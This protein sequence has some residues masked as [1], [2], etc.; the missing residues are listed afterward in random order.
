MAN[1][2]FKYAERN[3]ENRIN[4]AEVGKDMTDMLAD[5]AR[6][7][8]EKK[9]AI[10]ADFR[11]FGKALSEAPMGE[12]AGRN[13][14]IT[15]YAND[16]S[17]YS[18]MINRLLKSGDLKLRDYNNV[19]A[20]L[21]EGTD[22]A[23]SLTKE[24]NT[25]FKLFQERS[26]IN[27]ETGLPYNQD[28][29]E[30]VLGN[31]QGFGNYADH[32]LWINPTTGRLSLGKTVTDDKGNVTLSKD[33]GS[34]VPVNS[35]R[36]RIRTQYDMYDMNAASAGMVEQ[37]KELIVVKKKDGVLTES[38]PTKDKDVQK[39]L[40][41]HAESVVAI[42][43][44]VSSILTNTV[45]TNP[46]SETGESFG[47]TYVPSEAAEN[48]NLILLINN[49]L[50]ESAGIPMPAFLD[51][52]EAL[53]KYLRK[54]YGSGS[55]LDETSENYVSEDEIK[56]IV[57]NNTK[58]I[59][60]A[61]DTVKTSLLSKIDY[62]ETPT[63]IFDPNR[64]AV[65]Y[66]QQAESRRI[67]KTAVTNLADIW[68]GTKSEMGAA[69]GF[70]EGL[71]PNVVKIYA[72]PNN[73][74]NILI[75]RNV[76]GKVVTMLPFP[77]GDSVEDFVTRIYTNIVPG[78]K[79]LDRAL[80]DSGI[81]DKMEEVDGV[82]VKKKKTQNQGAAGIDNTVS[83]GPRPFSAIVA[84]GSDEL[85]MTSENYH[86]EAFEGV[87]VNEGRKQAS[88]ETSV[89]SQSGVLDAQVKYMPEVEAVVSEFW[90][91]DYP[92]TSIYVPG[93]MNMPILVPSNQDATVFKE[94]NRL[95]MDSYKYNPPKRLTPN[96]FKNLFLTSK[97]FDKYNN[98]KVTEKFFK[99][100]N[101]EGGVGSSKAE[102]AA[103]KAA[104]LAKKEADAAAATGAPDTTTGSGS[105][106][107]I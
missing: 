43:T 88:A 60:V 30:F 97:I 106:D 92:A 10:D 89:L 82:M 1:T 105:L 103:N 98:Q 34:F 66:L 33:T 57:A 93:V 104:A 84:G 100:F 9:A 26:E 64:N 58:Q 107:D 56:L 24:F 42:P 41:L 37:L 102:A 29:E 28:L 5:E 94:I 2:Y 44:N 39:A 101:W 38:D 49:P 36:N 95:I 53:A 61:K 6:V 35:L 81:G 31:A 83:Q 40:E 3:A 22:E 86:D 8:G 54:N 59:K 90:S 45:N 21:K 55:A 11:E 46:N 71:D 76:N 69:L 51:S 32:R 25:A 18:L 74:D 7:R 48:E 78:G 67:A 16:A 12:H 4:W 91:V 77:K 85:P 27:P 75:D 13:E 47:F 72:D 14:L 73:L 23:F 17:E 19:S 80:K 15:E 52:E 68:W 62:E 79:D 70:V 50:Q 63:P 20:N 99:E 96:D 65:L 87:K